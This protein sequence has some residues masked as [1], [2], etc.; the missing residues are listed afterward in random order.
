MIRS[1]GVCGVLILLTLNFGACYGFAFSFGR[2]PGPG[3][4]SQFNTASMDMPHAVASRGSPFSTS[5]VP[6][7]HNMSLCHGLEYQRMRLPNLLDHDTID[8]VLEQSA[9]WVHLKKLR[10]HA[11]TQKFLCSLFAPVCLETPIYPCRSL[12]EAV[13]TSCE[14]AMLKFGYPW[15]EMVNCDKFP[16]GDMCVTA[17]SKDDGES[18]VCRACSQPANSE[19]LLDNY[20][21]ADFVIRARARRAKDGTVLRTKMS[22]I[23]KV[24]ETIISK[25]DLRSPEF[26]NA[27]MT[28]C[29]SG[30]DRKIAKKNPHLLLM[31]TRDGDG[32]LVPTFIME[33]KRGSDAFK[34]A[35]KKM[36]KINCAHP[37]VV[38]NNPID[39]VTGRKTE[40]ARRDRQPDSNGGSQES[41]DEDSMEVK[42]EQPKIQ[43]DLSENFRREMELHNIAAQQEKARE[44]ELARREKRRKDRRRKL[45]RRKPETPRTDEDAEEVSS[46]PKTRTLP[47]KRKPTSTTTEDAAEDVRE[48]ATEASHPR[49]GQPFHDLTYH[50]TGNGELEMVVEPPAENTDEIKIEKKI[51]L[52]L[53]HHGSHRSEGH[54]ESPR[55]HDAHLPGLKSHGDAHPS[56]HHQQK[57]HIEAH[58]DHAV[59]RHDHPT[60]HKEHHSTAQEGGP[61]THQEHPNKEVPLHREDDPS[62]KVHHHHH[63]HHHIEETAEIAT[64]TE[65]AATEIP[66]RPGDGEDATA[67]D[68]IAIPSKDEILKLAG[69]DPSHHKAHHTHH[70]RQQHAT[71]RVIEDDDLVTTE[72]VRKPHEIRHE[73]HSKTHREYHHEVKAPASATPEEEMS[74][75]P[76]VKEEFI[77]VL[78]VIPDEMKGEAEGDAT[79]TDDLTTSTTEAVRT[80]P[81]TLTTTTTT[82]TTIETASEPPTSVPRRGRKRKNG[83]RRHHKKKKKEYD[84]EGV[85]QDE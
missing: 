80:L 14:S 52:P 60:N 2:H 81:T 33:W 17:G 28:Q 21:R 49:G 23:F 38:G 18:A 37:A 54:R 8:E 59:A 64:T 45:E 34:K 63:H 76:P 53:E 22:R 77:T 85:P 44:E 6:I 40:S 7:P 82:T 48:A 69:E 20:C 39:P 12:C 43:F 78:P 10:C 5:C 35:I 51:D 83:R 75:M 25:K 4:W 56:D 73:E 29:C 61:T 36:Q 27:N 68:S 42:K 16:E 19:S 65:S 46:E 79:E 30:L 84:V 24:T 11:D 71:V 3:E 58:E 15:P 31:G 41:D 62:A 13:R 1:K 55:H 72:D 57:H 67:D 47:P 74:T 9:S 32:N 50:K 26:R 70:Q 66:M